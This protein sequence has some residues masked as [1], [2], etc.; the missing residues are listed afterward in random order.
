MADNLPCRFLQTGERSS[1]LSQ[2]KQNL[3]DRYFITQH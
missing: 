3:L 1:H 2:L